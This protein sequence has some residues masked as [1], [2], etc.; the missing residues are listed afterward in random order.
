M[1][2]LVEYITERLNPRHLGKVSKF[3]VGKPAEEAADFLKSCGFKE[4]KYA[5]PRGL[6]QIYRMFNTSKC[7]VFMIS[8]GEGPWLRFADTS[9]YSIPDKNPVFYYQPTYS[10]PYW[11]ESNYDGNMELS[12]EEFLSDLA[13][14]LG[15]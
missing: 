14:Y 2:N 12:E 15:I 13:E 1:Y 11:K 3:P 8:S 7:K 9:K 6:A 10:R 4:I 5:G